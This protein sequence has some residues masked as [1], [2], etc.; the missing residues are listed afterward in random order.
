MTRN[1]AKFLDT[2][3]PSQIFFCLISFDD[4]IKIFFFITPGT[5]AGP[6]CPGM[7]VKKQVKEASQNLR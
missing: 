2:F 7:P 4:F 5:P 6:T 3:N 1:F